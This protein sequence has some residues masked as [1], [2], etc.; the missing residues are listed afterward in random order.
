M[1][2]ILL[3]YIKLIVA[4]VFGSVLGV[5]RK[6]AGKIAGMRTF[7]LVSL[8]SCLL[9]VASQMVTGQY[10]GQ[11]TFDP[12]RLAAGIITGIGFLGAGTIYFHDSKLSGLTTAAGLWVSAG[13]GIT[14]GFGLFTLATVA[15]LLVFVSFTFFKRIETSLRV[16]FQSRG[17]HEDDHDS[18]HHHES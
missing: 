12:M 17:G 8:G 5:Q 16:Y 10:I 14:V 6:Y 3:P 9:I 18:L 4:L 1:E 2:I 13:I 11:T 15:T 7:G